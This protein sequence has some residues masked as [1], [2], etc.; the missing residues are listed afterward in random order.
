M[1]GCATEYD[2]KHGFGGRCELRAGILQR[3]D[4]Y[5]SGGG[6]FNP[7]LAD[8]AEVRAL[9]SDCREEIEAKNIVLS[10]ALMH[11]DFVIEQR[12]KAR[13]SLRKA[14]SVIRFVPDADA[15]KKATMDL[16]AAIYSG[17]DYPA[18][19]MLMDKLRVAVFVNVRR[20]SNT[21]PRGDH[22][23]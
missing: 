20:E 19:A 9:L 15:V 4:A 8:H 2:G 14:R 16:N 21:K 13:A 5:M 11:R 3:I 12:D 18:L 7:E 10:A 6:L 22:E 17:K 1:P 23:R